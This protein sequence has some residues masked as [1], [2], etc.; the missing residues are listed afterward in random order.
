[1][2]VQPLTSALKC[3]ELLDV[4]ASQPGAARISELGR[5]VGA[6]RAT[7]YQRLLTLA[8]AGWVD[9]LPDGSYRLSTRACR[10]AATALN[11]A[12][13]GDRVQPILDDLARRTGEAI[14]LVMREDKRLIIVQ[15][16]EAQGVLRTDLRAGAEL[17][18]VDSA[19]GAIW[20][21]FGESGLAEQLRREGIK[22]PA[23][24]R[25]QKVR[26]SKVSIGG[27]GATLAGISAMAVPVV[28]ANGRLCASL[29]LTS[30]ESRFQSDSH[31]PLLVTAAA[32]ISDVLAHG[33]AHRSW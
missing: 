30:P 24:T 17:S 28:A 9:R 33:H 19:S 20:L 11:Q 18:F 26:A 31:L 8:T 32:H 14:S 25:I 12:G 2:N 7:T 1:M 3:L 27:G 22:L 15:R 13:L 5:L 21:A 29:S 6:S 16:A 4:L 10:V 23:K